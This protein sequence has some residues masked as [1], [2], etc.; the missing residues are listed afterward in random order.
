MSGS[1]EH[2]SVGGQTAA[3]PSS[4]MIAKYS[5]AGPRYTSYPTAVEFTSD[6]TADD[7]RRLL[8]E[9]FSSADAASGLS[10]YMHLPFCRTLCYFC[11]CNKVISQDRSVV[12][13]Y[14]KALEGELN[15]Y[16]EL[17]ERSA[18]TLPES[19]QLHWGGGTPNYLLP[20]ELAAVFNAAVSRF[21]LAKDADVSIEVD[22]RTTFE[23][24]VE[25]LAELGF[26]RIS[27]GVQ[28]FDS[29][30]QEA[31]N[32]IQ[33]F[34][35]TEQV[36]NWARAAGFGGVNVDLIY[37]LPL[38]TTGGFG[39]TIEQVIA[40]KP[41]RIA[42]YGYAHVTW[43]TKV[44]RALERAPLPT[45]AERIELFLCA[46]ERLTAAGYVHIGMDHFALPSD[47]LSRSLA[48]GTLNR[49]FMGYSTNRGSKIFGFGASSI[50][51][52][53]CAFA[54]NI[55]DI[56]AYQQRIEQGVWPL[57]RGLLRSREDRL[58][59]D[60]I[61]ELMC[62]GVLDLE[63]L[64]REWGI[65]PIEY[66]ADALP[67]LGDLAAD[68]LVRLGGGEIRVTALGRYFQR[69]I[70]MSFDA[71]LQRHRAEKKS[72]FSQAV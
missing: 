41:E 69:N 10:L 29:K 59:G 54:Q 61:Q 27:L 46:L 33:S 6:F 25:T 28:D 68:G 4:E 40:I 64:G 49:N 65:N 39:R 8:I 5:V 14:I 62:R 12:A 71:Y 23:E 17:F 13:P 16:S 22:P 7:W 30:V 57:E 21:P 1:I 11:A 42:L 43:K 31:I 2:S 37:G 24:Q 36:I 51:T 19:D 20:E 35:C 9:E 53:D 58:R 38:Q 52:L 26:N 47:G 3:V 63:R 48:A 60:V 15:L 72:V 56:P 45:P 32:R 34:E 67:A 55:K 70:A 18:I 66:F 44:Q 50:S